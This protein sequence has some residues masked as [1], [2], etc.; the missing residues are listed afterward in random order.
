VSGVSSAPPTVT[1]RFRI[2]RQYARLMVL[3]VATGLLGAVGNV[4]FRAAIDG[5]RWVFLDHLGVPLALVAGAAALLVLDRLFPH[6]VLGYGFPRFLEMLHLEGAR[7]K[8][9]WMIV[10][11]LGAAISLGSGAAVGREGPIAQIGGSIGAAVAMLT[12]L[13]AEQRKVLVACG[14]AAGIATTFNAPLG[15]LMF[16]QEIVLLG[17]AQLA[18]FSLIV[19]ATTS[20]VIASRGLFGSLPVFVVP[21]FTLESYWE[22]LTYGLLG[23]V[24]GLLAAVYTRLFHATAARLRR[25]PLPRPVVLVVGLG[26]VG[27]LDVAVPGNVSDGYGVVNDALAGRLDWPAMSLLAVAK[28]VGSSLS[29]GCGAPG[30]VFGPIFF[31]GAMTGGSFRAL[32][33]LLLPGLTGPRGSYALV[34]LGAFLAAATHAPLTAVFLLFEM[35]Q[36]YA[37]AVPALITTIVGLMVATAL[38]PESIDT[39]GLTAE[40]KSLHVSADRVM[41]ER[42]PVESVFRR[43]YDAIPDDCPLPDV[44]Q[45]V[46]RSRS[47]TFPVIDRTGALLGVLAFAELRTLLI[48]QKVDPALRARD[49]ADPPPRPLTPETS[50][51]EAFRRMESEGVDDLPVVDAADARRLLG[52]LSRADLIAAFNRTVATLGGAP[53]PAWLQR[54]EPRWDDQY[55]VVPVD[56]PPDW[57]GR[58]LRD[59]DCRARF[60]V[61]VLAVRRRDAG[62]RVWDLPDPARALERGDVL[63]MAGTVD[64]V[65]AF[66]PDVA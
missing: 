53:M 31:I 10:K 2:E 4:V 16:A 47:S 26:L 34:G 59:V 11:T 25:L 15:A 3:A 23:V 5:A 29:L 43:Q 12:R 28:V 58:S 20:A 44:L 1:E 33:A 52:M 6:E 13:S 55:R 51:G 24:L 14:A 30:G 38:E 8:R 66:V 35:T 56:V 62:D 41:L 54:A 64:A 40:G 48:E 63:M 50:L 61:A 45:I 42:I 9:R 27:L 60:G 39:L 65:G 21:P 36:S 32:S 37:V 22:C 49:L 17:E 19:I 57:I 46:G 7:V 18:N